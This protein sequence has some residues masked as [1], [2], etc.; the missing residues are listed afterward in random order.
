MRKPRRRRGQQL[1]AL[2]ATGDKESKRGHSGR[3]VQVLRRTSQLEKA[4]GYRDICGTVG[5]CGGVPS[6]AN[7]LSPGWLCGGGTEERGELGPDGAR[8]ALRARPTPLPQ[9]VTSTCGEPSSRQT[10][11]F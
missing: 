3:K 6:S 4:E 2:S 8:G 5:T 10:P 11:C 9:H 7:A 1:S